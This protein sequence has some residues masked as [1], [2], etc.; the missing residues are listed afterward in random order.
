M[1][2]KIR[3]YF[4]QNLPSIRFTTLTLILTI[5]AILIAYSQLSISRAKPILQGHYISQFIARE[6]IQ[7]IGDSMVDE[8]FSGIIEQGAI[9]ENPQYANLIG[10]L[11]PISRTI[12]ASPLEVIVIVE[13]TGSK[14]AKNVSIAL[15]STEKIASFSAESLSRWEIIDGGI[16]SNHITFSFERIS[17]RE[18]VIANVTYSPIKDATDLL[19]LRVTESSLGNWPPFLIT[20]NEVDRMR[21]PSFVI[22]PSES[23]PLSLD[24]VVRVTSDE[25]TLQ[26]LVHA[27]RL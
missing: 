15:E 14:A 13:N 20:K 18:I 11:L 22:I 25:T 24:P 7:E 8:L 1:I 6:G 10:D 27:S 19:E 4:V 3:S 12:Q 9:Q 26:K 23:N 16:G 21:F 2:T 17:K 5:I